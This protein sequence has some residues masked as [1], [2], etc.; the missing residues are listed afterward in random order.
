MYVSVIRRKSV[1]TQANSLV[2]ARYRLTLTEQKLLLSLVSL[3]APEDEEFQDYA[4][5]VK[6]FA[7]LIRTKNQNYYKEMSEIL[8]RLMGRVLHI[9]QDGDWHKVHWIGYARHRK[10]SGT[11]TVRFDPFL[12]P[13]LLQLK[14]RF[15]SYQIGAI[16]QF[17]SSYSIRIY[18][19]L[20]QYERLGERRLSVAELRQRLDIA[21]NEYGRHADFRRRILL[22]A[23]E[24]I[25]QKSDI[26]ISFTQAKRGTKVTDVVF[27]IRG[28]KEG[29]PAPKDR[30]KKV[31]KEGRRRETGKMM[32]ILRGRNIEKQQ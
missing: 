26:M 23:V 28:K 6:S 7:D 32:A 18:Q 3:I 14:N 8:E 31:S 9:E 20:K 13:Y 1:V 21:E 22:P 12:K 29:I 19:L 5:E 2:E 10:G 24:D 16:A 4:L 11:I 15:T 27:T 25:N 17:R 30:P